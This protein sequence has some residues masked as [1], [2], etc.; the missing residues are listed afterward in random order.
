MS[1]RRA[2][3]PVPK[4]E[5]I[6]GTVEK[7]PLSLRER[8]RQQMTEQHPVHEA[9]LAAFENVGG[10]ERLTGWAEDNY[11]DFVTIFARM[12]P[13]KGEGGSGRI[14]IQINNKLGPTALDE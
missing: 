9:F 11:K 13:T 4:S 10:I 7:Q 12:A 1:K 2:L 5:P 8:M 6:E 3:K 14:Q